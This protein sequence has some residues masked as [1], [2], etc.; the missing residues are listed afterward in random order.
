MP[1]SALNWT[2]AAL[3]M[4]AMKSRLS[5]LD[6]DHNTRIHLATCAIHT[7][8]LEG[9]CRRSGPEIRPLHRDLQWSIVLSG[10]SISG[11]WRTA[12]I[13]AEESPFLCSYMAKLSTQSHGLKHYPPHQVW[14]EYLD[15]STCECTLSPFHG[16]SWHP[17]ATYYF[18]YIL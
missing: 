18:Q 12:S 2:M 3:F 17:L 9:L 8:P 10:G 5:I 6:P 11:I 4:P 1:W 7:I 13:P 15:H 14:G 16:P